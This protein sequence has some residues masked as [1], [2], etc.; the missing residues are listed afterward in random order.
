MKTR[1]LLLAFMAALLAA[2]LARATSE[3]LLQRLTPQGKVTDLAGV[4]T[5]NDRQALESY[6]REVEQKTT[7]EIAVVALRTLEGGEI[8][9]FARRL[10]NQW[11]IG[12]QDKNNGVLLL[13]AVQ[14][15]AVKIEVGVGLGAT[16]APGA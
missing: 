3:E 4:F 14:D 1:S 2:G 6:L 12:K 15:G 7:A 9:D 10:F 13:A 5:P 16:A 11:G 8:S